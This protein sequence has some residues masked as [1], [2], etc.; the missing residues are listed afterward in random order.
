MYYWTSTLSTRAAACI[1]S[2]F[3]AGGVIEIFRQPFVVSAE[4]ATEGAHEFVAV[5][6]P[7]PA[8]S[9]VLPAPEPRVK[10]P[11]GSSQE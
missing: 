1:T 9:T 5:E 10:V 2:V 8:A 3:A 11:I 6:L 7:E 4:I